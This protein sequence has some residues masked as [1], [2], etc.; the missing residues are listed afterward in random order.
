MRGYFCQQS[1]V[2]SLI[3]LLSGAAAE[4]A[5][6][7]PSVDDALKLRPVQAD[8]PYEK[9]SA[10]DVKDC[11][12]KAEK[13]AGATAWVVRGP[14]GSV[15][16]QFADSN[17]DNV[18][19]TWSYYQNG[20]ETYRDVD[21]DFNGKADQY[22]WFQTAGSRWAIDK[23]ED[24][25]IDSWRSISPEE[26]AEEVVIA[27]RTRDAARF[28]R[29][30]INS[31]DQKQLGFSRDLGASVKTRLQGAQ[32]A[33]TKLA[34]SKGIGAKARFSDFGGL[35]PGLVPAGAHGLGKD[36]LVYENA[37]AMVLDGDEH[38]QLQL[39]A[40]LRVGD[41]W[42]LIDGPRLGNE[43]FAGGFFYT[44]PG[45]AD[46]VGPV[47]SAPNARMQKLLAEMEKLDQQYALASNK[48]KPDLNVK[49]ADILERV[50]AAAPKGRDRNQWYEQL[51]DM[52]SAAVQDGSYPKGGQRLAKLES[53]LAKQ[54]ATAELVT[55]FKFR[56]LQADNSLRLAAP[57]ADYAKIQE[58]WLKELESFVKDHADSKHAAEALLQLAMAS[59][60]SGEEDNAVDWYRKI[61][62]QFPTSQSAAKAKGAV[63]R[64]TCEGKRIALSG[65]SVRGGQVSLGKYRG[66][67]VIVQYWT[68]VYPSCKAEHAVLKELYQKYGG[69]KQFDVL[70]IN[71]DYDREALLDYLED[72]RLPWQQIFEPGGF[73]SRPANEMGVVI[74]PL[75][76]L[77]D[78]QGVVAASDVTAEQLEDQLKEMLGEPAKKSGGARRTAR[79][80]N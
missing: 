67:P 48:Q 55:H 69:G 57:K 27:L 40:M 79:L 15:L 20:L 33:F 58:L 47:Q 80:K 77:I 49:R 17:S 29:L 8:V 5:I 52:I 35:R 46:A 56:R 18:V 11:T 2:I 36:A 19:D 61:V 60:F 26:V 3:C 16:R 22:R 23:N 50:A 13:I 9:P 38:L 51:A 41:A 39:G 10:K 31:S 25:K 21:A 34:D 53:A 37:W 65:D 28:R 72:N 43:A 30:L 71:L 63:Q 62:K 12:I 66:K 44:N 73:D 78:E 42:K 75:M 64:L 45:Q 1:L 32:A 70:G 7:A 24:G 68:S 54:K 4:P 14:R 6:A 76:L 59:E 74:L